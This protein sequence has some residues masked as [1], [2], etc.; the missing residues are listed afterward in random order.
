[1][2]HNSNGRSSQADVPPHVIRQVLQL[3][4]SRGHSPERLCR[5]LG[6]V[7]E[8]LRDSDFRVSYRQTSLLVQ[9]AMKVCGDPAMGIATGARQT[10]VSF[11]LPGLGM[12][13]CPTL[14]E[15]LSYLIK[16]Q[17]SAGAITDNKYLLDERHFTVEATPRFHDPEMEPFFVEEVLV[18]GV[19]LARSLVGSHYRPAGLE[20]RYPKPAYASAYSEFFRC[21]VSYNAPVNRLISDAAWYHCPL[22]T[23]DSFMEVSMQAQIDQLLTNLPARDDLVESVLAVLRAEVDDM[24]PLSVISAALNFS[25]RTLRRRLSE[26]DTSYQGLVDQVRYESA[27]DLLKRTDMSL[28]EIAMATGFT[29]AR[30]FRRAFKRWAGVL[31]NQLRHGSPP[32]PDLTEL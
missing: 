22:P 18:S 8:N 11:G 4:G 9:R 16:Y 15:A 17:R 24:P 29:D 25:E 21:P 23:Y 3:A 20:L 12:L 28:V 14:G 5:S 26:L 30:N 27:V 6:F 2:Q 1:M 7:L 19:A 10:V 32:E 31:P 13:T